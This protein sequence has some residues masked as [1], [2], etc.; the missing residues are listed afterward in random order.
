MNV[1]QLDENDSP[2]Q[3]LLQ[4]KTT[5]KQE[6]PLIPEHMGTTIFHKIKMGLQENSTQ[7]EDIS[8]HDKKDIAWIGLPGNPLKSAGD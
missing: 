8:H 5:I 3:L 2:Y 1:L 6:W 4:I 7:L